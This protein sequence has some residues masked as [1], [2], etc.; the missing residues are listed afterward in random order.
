MTDGPW[1]SPLAR[2]VAL[3]LAVRIGVCLLWPTAPSWDGHFYARLAAQLARG[4]GYAEPLAH[5]DVATA[6]WPPG[7]PFALLGPIALGAPPSLAAVVVNLVAAVVAVV[8]V[9]RATDALHGPG[10]AQR[11]ARIYALYPGLALWSAATMTET[12]TGALVAVALLLALQRSAFVAGVALGLAALTRPP[13]L[14]LL[15]APLAAGAR[16]RALTLCL[17]GAVAV[18]A[19]WTARNARALDAPSLISTNGG[20]NLLIGATSPHGGYDSPRGRHPACEQAIGEVARDRCWRDAARAEIRRA[21]GAWLVR[22]ALR[23]ARTFA[24]ELDP[25]AHLAWSA[26]PPPR[27]VRVA[28]GAL[29]TLAWW[30]LLARAARG[31]DRAASSRVA[32]LAVGATAL[33][34]FVFLGADRYHLVLVPLLCPLAA[35]SSR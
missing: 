23:V 15:A 4:A 21:P 8:A 17:L 32:V 20:S 12:L 10:V 26:R 29:C 9:Y 27:P 13:S 22:G 6:F 11:A 28:L 5:G 19:P 2:C 18:V 30:V 33:T 34:H 35:R 14:L 25:A 1:R 16:G 7:L 24:L 31:L 3:T